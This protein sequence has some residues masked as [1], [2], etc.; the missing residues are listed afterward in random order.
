M[1]LII[2]ECNAKELEANRGFFDSITDAMSRICGSL[3]RVKISDAAIANA[4][5]NLNKPDDEEEEEEEEE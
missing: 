1:N 3:G 2:L 4:L 5:T